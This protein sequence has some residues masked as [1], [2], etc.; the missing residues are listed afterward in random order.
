[1]TQPFGPTTN[2]NPSTAR[3]LNDLASDVSD[4]KSEPASSSNRATNASGDS[5][6]LNVFPAIITGSA[7]L[8]SNKWKYSWVEHVPG[9]TPPAGA[10]VGCRRSEV[11][12]DAF[13][14]FAVNGAEYDNSSSADYQSY[15]ELVKNDAVAAVTLLPI[16]GETN[17]T[18]GTSARQPMVLMMELPIEDS[19]N[20]GARYMFF[21]ANSVK[22]EC[23]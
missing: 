1:M 6:R 5:Y 21:A 17:A 22:V 13:T 10:T 19:T 7:S 4:I 23:A 12:G 16:G 20:S 2:I 8:S 9:T 14:F 11:G 3:S 18:D 15:G